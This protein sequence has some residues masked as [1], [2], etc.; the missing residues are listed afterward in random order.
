MRAVLSTKKTSGGG[1]A[2]ALINRFGA[3][4]RGATIVEFGL[5]ALPF[6]A[7]LMAI[8]ETGLMFFAGQTLETAVGN[9]A[10][11]IRTGQAQE[12]GFDEARFREE[13][14]HLAGLVMDCENKLKLDVKVFPVFEAIDLSPGIGEN[15][16]VDDAGFTFEPGH[17][18]DIVVVRAF[19]DW[20]VFANILGFTLDSGNGSHLLT[21]TVAFRNEPFPW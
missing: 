8:L 21:A 16:E 15:G 12:Q 1:N 6:F 20:P 17:G 4:Q 5:I 13:I 7:L 9:A 19:Y 10:R 11:M 3:S 2:P 14:C 18:N